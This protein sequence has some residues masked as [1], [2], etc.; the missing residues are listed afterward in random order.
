MTLCTPGCSAVAAAAFSASAIRKYDI[1]N[2][3]LY[4]PYCHEP[5]A[6]T[7]DTAVDQVTCMDIGNLTAGG[8][9]LQNYIEWDLLHLLWPVMPAVAARLVGVL[10]ELSMEW[11]CAS[12]HACQH[13]Q[14]TAALAPTS[15]CKQ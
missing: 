4:S 15:Y 1:T 6:A 7:A 2:A 13:Y 11:L 8:M 9:T 12:S 14:C 10:V 5:P 3:P